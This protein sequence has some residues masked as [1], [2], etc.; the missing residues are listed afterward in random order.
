MKNFKLFMLLL[1]FPVLVYSQ[2]EEAGIW[3]NQTIWL[4]N[5]S[6]IPNN[7]T[8]MPVG[9]II[10]PQEILTEDRIMEIKMTGNGSKDEM[11]RLQKELD[12]LN[13]LGSTVGFN[14]MDGSGVVPADL[15]PPFETDAIGNT[16]IH[17]TN[18][19]LAS[20][21]A[22]CTEES[23]TNAGRIWAVLAF[24]TTGAPDSI[25][26]YSSGNGGLSWTLRANG[27]LGGTNRI[28]FDQMDMEIISNASGTHVWIVFGY[29]ETGGTGR[30]RCGGL[31]FNPSPFAGNFFTLIWPGDSA[32][33]RYYNPRI[34]SD[35]SRYTANAWTYIIASFDSVATAP[36]RNNKQKYV[37][38]LNPYT[39]TPAFSY[40]APGFFWNTTPNDGLVRDLHSDI[41]YFY[42]GTSDSIIV[43]F[44]NIRDSTKIFFAKTGIGTPSP[45]SIGAGGSIGG[46]QNTHHKQY[47]RI[48]S[49][50]NS[51]GSIYCVFRQNSD[52]FKVKYFRTTNYGNFNT[53]FQSVLLPQDG[54]SVAGPPDIVG[55][56]NVDRHY[57]I[58]R[59]DGLPDSA[60]YYVFSSGG[61]VGDGRRMNGQS[62]ITGTLSPKAGFRYIN[63]DS[64][65]AVYSVNGPYDL[66]AAQGCSGAIVGISENELPVKFEL[67]QNYPNP[68]NPVTT[69]KF[70][71]PKNTH[72]KLVVYDMLGKE[73]ST[74][75]NNV[76]AS[77]NY[78]V[79]FNAN[80]FASGVYFYKIEVEGFSDIKKMMLIK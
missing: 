2:T 13:G 11:I 52:G 40:Y 12:G 17:N 8:G 62:L 60:M 6:E 48:S 54:N 46:I 39:T 20:G 43:S 59:L 24:R 5:D 22:T 64:C 32:N 16:L 79:D 41:A 29:R 57:F 74:L 66:W 80:S 42:N 50:G 19:K 38:C 15:Q 75:V 44:S 1:F 18:S 45:S 71:I 9:R 30:W 72:V 14:P 21:I 63:N 35:N 73:V 65:F 37:R 51:N 36:S 70:S 77:G 3:Q 25:R 78:A 56:R 49:N 31:I 55:R 53:M 69:I 61:F 67:N 26:L 4:G 68:F 34:T 76:L 7:V 10:S 28:N 33:K 27:W 58:Y 23:G 47:A